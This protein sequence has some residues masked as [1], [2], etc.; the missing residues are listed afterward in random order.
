M[1]ETI[2]IAIV[3]R[4]KKTHIEAFE[5]A[6]T[7]FA[8]RSLAE[9]GAR[10]VHC[11]YPPPGSDSTEYGIL[12]SFASAADRDAFYE[13]PLYKEWLARIAPMVEGE[14]TY[15]RLEG[16]EAWFRDTAEPMPPRWKMALL[17]WI[18]VW[19]VSMIVPALLLPLL[20][21]KFPQLLAS[22]VIAGGIVAVLTWGAMPLL[23]KL[24][25][26]WLH[27]GNRTS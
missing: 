20:G 4:V 25:H 11:L 21:P 18:A 22:G 6:L 5:R 16:L 8:S 23:V 7:E 17:T 24:A 3:R 27:P 9:P 13:T 15:R 1:A 19:P 2:H 14:P 10:G 12:R 26:P